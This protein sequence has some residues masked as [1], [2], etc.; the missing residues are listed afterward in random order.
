MRSTLLE[1]EYQLAFIFQRQE[2]H[3]VVAMC[4]MQ[5]VRPDDQLGQFP[6]T[7]LGSKGHGTGCLPGSSTGPSAQ[8]RHGRGG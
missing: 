8:Y 6:R 5:Y 2:H 7:V 3:A 1:L 4:V